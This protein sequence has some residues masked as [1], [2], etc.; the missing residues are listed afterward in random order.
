MP[1]SHKKFHSTDGKR[2]ILVVDDEPINRMLLEG[3]LEEEYEVLTAADGREAIE[4]IRR[5]RDLL[6]LVLLDLLLPDMNGLDI[7]KEV[8]TSG[9]TQ[10]I[11]VIVM[12]SEQD[13]EVRSLVLGAI[14]FIPKPYP[15]PEVVLARIQKTIELSEDR[16]IIHHTERDVLTGL[17]NR[18]YFYQYAMQFDL[19]HKEIPMD[20]VVIDVNHFH[21]I[22][23][24]FGKSYGDSVLR[25][26]GERVR[27]IV[28]DSDGIVC[29]READTFL[30]Y[31]RHREDYQEVLDYASVGLS[32]DDSVNNRVRLRM[33]VYYNVD[34]DLDV[35]RRFDRAKQASDTVRNSFQKS[36]GYYDDTL[37]EAELFAEQLVEEFHTAIDQHQFC[38]YYQPKFDV[39]PEIPILASAEAL[40]RWQ[41]PTLGMISPGLFIPLF[42]ENGLIQEL[43]QYVWRTAAAQIREWKDRFHFSVPVSVNVS[44]IDMYDPELIPTFVGILNEYQISARELLLEITESAY[45]KDSEQIIE[46]VNRLRA[47]GFRVEM[48][49]FGTGY[50]SLNMISTL[51]IDAL[52]LDMQFIRNAFKEGRD[53]RML[54]VIIDIADYLS[55]PVIAEGVETEEQLHALKAMGCDMV[56]GYYFSRPLPAEDYEKYVVERKDQEKSLPPRTVRVQ[57]PDGEGEVSFGRIAQALSSG[58][59]CIYYVDIESNH[60][61]EFNSE[62]RFEDL[63]IERSG[64]DFFEDIMNYIA[65]LVYEEDKDRL[66]LC[67]KKETLLDQL[68]EP[69]PFSITYRVLLDGAP[70]YYNLKAVKSRRLDD[71]HIVIGVSNINEQ[72]K[73]AGQDALEPANSLNFNMLAYALTSDMECI[74]YVDMVSDTYKTFSANGEYTKIPL[75]MTGM[76][77]FREFR[78]NMEALI[79]EEDR[80]KVLASLNK[81]TLKKSLRDRSVF[82][83][84]YRLMIEGRCLYYQMKVVSAGGK[85]DPHIIIGISNVDAQVAQEEELKARQSKENV[86]YASIAQALAADYFSIYYVDP[87]T[88]EYFEYSS[89]LGYHGLD[90]ERSGE[91]FFDMDHTNALKSVFP[92][93]LPMVRSAIHKKKLLKTLEKNGTFTLTYRLL[94][95]GVPTYVHLKASLLEDAS[96]KHIVIGISNVDDQIRR[97]QEHIKAMR[98]ANRDAL[99]GVKSKHAYLEEEERVNQEIASGHTEEFAVAVCDL[100]DLKTVN[101]TLGHKAGDQYIRDAC[102]AIC[103]VFKHSPVFRVGGDE[104]VAILRGTD[105]ERRDS[106]KELM[107]QINEDKVN[108]GGAV[109]ACG[110]S[111]YLPGED[112]ILGSVFERADAAM[113]ENK[114][115]WKKV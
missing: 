19:F 69:Q 40:V 110:M 103:H 58:F 85:G 21:M 70:V 7:L 44:R 65:T 92:D 105:Y 100:N 87:E 39:R 12:T 55:V 5:Y 1:K 50:S 8:K 30:V 111:D 36:I 41:H 98:L 63:Q 108:Q 91:N 78:E 20:A 109:I 48:D 72:M 52:K 47:L 62:G 94:F 45:T 54:E 107:N 10:N 15:K 71:Q 37:H 66:S 79:C 76:N 99:T 3:Y 106:L 93:D 84:I 2:L 114:K 33:G 101:D 80:D 29:R 43:D 59:E 13:E 77:F 83:R 97:E 60:Y 89:H 34:K 23:E 95:D 51:P 11:P 96:G 81:E 35:E 25:R 49:D 32:G 14:D 38:V 112:K 18:E 73:Q 26:I 27:E 56:Q 104:F 42:E 88:D 17:Y 82:T 115:L 24:R 6:S 31:C 74:Y 61:V 46:T 57:D 67:L 86:T 113:Y 102:S 28:Q 4:K 68:M 53:T 90:P 22:N 9:V 64:S 75:H 16:D